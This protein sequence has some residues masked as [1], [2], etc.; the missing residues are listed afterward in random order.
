MG[1]NLDGAAEEITAS[2]FGDYGTVNLTGSDVGILSQINIDE[3]LVVTQIKVGFGAVLSDKYLTVL[4]RGHSSGV[5]IQIRVKFLDGNA[6]TA[7]FQY[8]A[9]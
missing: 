3:T 4:I 7:A 9:D 8:G 5:D 1:N 2:F 6:D